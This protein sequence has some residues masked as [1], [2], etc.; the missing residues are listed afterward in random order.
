MLNYQSDHDHSL[1]LLYLY[2]MSYVYESGHRATREEW[3][4][5]N[6]LHRIIPFFTVDV[7]HCA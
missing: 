3:A 7:M 6:Y 5:R 2:R 1:Y 4:S